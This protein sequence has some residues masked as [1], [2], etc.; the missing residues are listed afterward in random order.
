MN[1]ILVPS[2]KKHQQTMQD[3]RTADLVLARWSDGQ[4]DRQA[5]EERYL[6][7]F[8]HLYVEQW[9]SHELPA[10]DRPKISLFLSADTIRQYRAKL[11]PGRAE[12]G[13][14]V[15][16]DTLTNEDGIDNTNA[17]ETAK[18]EQHILETYEQNQMPLIL[19]DQSEWF[20]VGGDSCIFAPHNPIGTVG[21]NADTMIFSVDPCKCTIG[22]HGNRKVFGM[23][24]QTI[25]A[26]EARKLPWV[27]LDQD[28]NDEDV[29]SD[30]YYFDLYN[31]CRII[32][33]SNESAK[34]LPNPYINP[35]EVP[36][37]WIP[38]NANPGS[39]DGNSELR[40]LRILDKELNFRISDYAE[41]LRSGVLG[42][43]FVS[44]AGNNK[45]INLDKDFI[46]YLGDNGKAERLG[47]AGDG[48]DFLE[49]FNFLLDIYQKKTTIT[50]DVVGTKNA[51]A[52]SSGI[53]L[54]YKF[55][56]LQELIDE[57]R[58]VWDNA[59]KQ[60]NKQ[61]L[62]YKFGKGKYRNKPIYVNALPTDETVAATNAVKLVEAGLKARESAID[63]LNPNESAQEII[64]KISADQSK[65]PEFYKKES[66]N[67][68]PNSNNTL[69]KKV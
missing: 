69:N 23:H 5:R 61:I 17:V 10:G 22:I 54:Q 25:T 2:S 6:L 15:Y 53:A 27:H 8:T 52:V 64:K 28:I 30:I 37:F 44:G 40:H 20:F 59:L 3:K 7:Y 31:Y 47:L 41:R 21:K 9:L 56:S 57:K 43:V 50:D 68:F 66:T 34:V 67:N 24:E 16:D 55:L 1:D 19:H 4:K 32:N 29:L 39:L 26:Q 38:N 12:I 62:Y 13:I 60:L 35:Y 46:N 42:P 18:Y 11:F 63:D 49:Y 48:K 14:K 33:E 58:L 45:K 51:N 36:Y 65:N